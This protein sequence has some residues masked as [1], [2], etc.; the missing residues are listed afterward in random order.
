MILAAGLGT[1]L[2]PL[3]DHLPKALVEVEGVPMLERVILNLKKKGFDYIVINVHHFASLVRDFLDSRD[4]GIELR[5]SDE[6]DCLLDTGGGLVK[7]SGLLFK[8]N[9][10]PVV[11]HNVDI[12]S[13]VDFATLLSR[14][15][16]EKGEG[17]LLVSDR[18]SSRKLL[19][20]RDFLLKGWHDL[21]SGLYK[22]EPLEGKEDL[23]ELAFSGIYVLGRNHVE[24]MEKLLG[25]GKYSV[26]EYFLHPQRK[27][28]L[29]GV[30]Q[31]D[32]KLLDIGKPATLSQASEFLKLT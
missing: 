13:N 1:R 31:P 11:V 23:K 2:K 14:S 15:E 10:E 19:F 28:L 6:S 24:E 16:R 3:T 12:L 26:M 5:I 29:R 27:Q 21:K 4:F 22:P 20:D 7:A 25:W 8:D 18:D 30:E 32:L 17:R 9:D